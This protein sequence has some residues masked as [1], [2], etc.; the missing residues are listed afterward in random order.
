MAV[1]VELERRADVLEVANLFQR[2]LKDPALLATVQAMTK[3]VA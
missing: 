1:E 3:E 2:L